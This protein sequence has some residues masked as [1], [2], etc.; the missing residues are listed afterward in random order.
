MALTSKLVLRQS[1][2]LVMT[3]QLL[4]AIKLLQFS[5]I[6]LS[7]FVEE[8][9]ERNPLLERAEEPSDRLPSEPGLSEAPAE[10]SSDHQSTEDGFDPGETDDNFSGLDATEGDWAREDLAT[11]RA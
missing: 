4:Q 10:A 6:E 9:L 3:P 5:N 2:S 7:A 8:E 11:D 1:Q